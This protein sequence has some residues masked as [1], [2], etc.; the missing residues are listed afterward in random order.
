VYA[1]QLKAAVLVSC[2]GR[3]VP[4]LVTTSSGLV[5]A[6]RRACRAAMVAKEGRMTG[7]VR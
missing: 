7:V 2:G 6:E 5:E 1:G 4:N 3:G